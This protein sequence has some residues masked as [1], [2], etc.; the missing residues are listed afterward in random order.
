MARPALFEWTA[1]EYEHNPK[2]A[3]W[4]WALGIIAVAA[5]IA[6]ILFANYLLAVLIII[7]TITVMLHGARHPP[8]HI[9][10]VVEHGLM[11]GDDLYPYHRMISFAVLEDIEGELPPLLSIKT[12]SWLT[13]HLAVPL[14]DVDAD[15]VYAH[16]LMHVDEARHRHTLTDLV[17]GW[18]GF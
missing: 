3:D 1:H 18:L 2:T 6:S 16:F 13:P 17:A 11:I 7:A 12:E 15:A 9:F 5:T 10:R 4:Y 8:E 14:K